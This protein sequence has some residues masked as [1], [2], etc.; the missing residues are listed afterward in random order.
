MIKRIEKSTKKN[1]MTIA[2]TTALFGSLLTACSITET[3]TASTSNKDEKTQATGSEHKLIDSELDRQLETILAN[4]NLWVSNDKYAQYS[5][6]DL[7]HNGRLEVMSYYT[8]GTSGYNNGSMYEVTEDLSGLEKCQLISSFS[9]RTTY[10]DTALDLVITGYNEAQNTYYYE[11]TDVDLSS[12][13]GCINTTVMLSYKDGVAKADHLARVTLNKDCD[14]RT[15][16]AMNGTEITEDEFDAIIAD[17]MKDNELVEGI[18]YF[19]WFSLTDE[20]KLKQDMQDA[21][22]TFTKEE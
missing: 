10:P 12:E 15:Y 21:Y 18:T 3:Q 9:D 17:Y 20:I 13:Q 1:I 7:D 5:V 8:E 19:K 4:K 11:F 6:F 14:K 16:E 22:T 2:L